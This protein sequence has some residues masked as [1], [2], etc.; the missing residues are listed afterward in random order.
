MAGFQVSTMGRWI[1]IF[2]DRAS[3]FQLVHSCLA[4]Y[5]IIALS[6]L[7]DLSLWCDNPSIAQIDISAHLRSFTLSRS[8]AHFP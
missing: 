1:G 3:F 8:T 7:L 2:T 6:T 5:P 4:L